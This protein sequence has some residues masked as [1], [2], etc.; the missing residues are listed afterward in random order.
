MIKQDSG[1][2]NKVSGFSLVEL[3]IGT[4]IL[5]IL[6]AIAIAVFSHITDRNQLASAT[7]E[8]VWSLKFARSEAIKNNKRVILC[9]SVDQ[10]N[11]SGSWHHG[12]ILFIDHNNTAKPDSAAAIRHVRHAFPKQVS[13]T[14]NAKIKSNIAYQ[15]TGLLGATSGLLQNGIFTI[16]VGKDYS[17]Q[18]VIST[19]GRPALAKPK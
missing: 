15:P 16:E 7:N 4:A 2:R 18:I 11:C 10:H 13:I 12:W 1:T 19:S 14:G 8:L 5:A 9:A 17:Q 6:A 3:L